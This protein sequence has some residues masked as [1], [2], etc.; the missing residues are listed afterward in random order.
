MKITYV[1]YSGYAIETENFNLLI[2]YYEDSCTPKE[3]GW[4]H[5]YLL[6][7]PKK[8][9]ILSTHSHFDHFNPEILSWKTVK[10]DIVYLFSKD[11]LDNASAQKEDAIYLDKGDTYCDDLLTIKAYGSTDIGV[12]FLLRFDNRSI[13]HAGDLNN[14]HWK[15]EVPASEALEYE[16]NFLNELEL[17]ATNVDY[18]DLAM[19]PVDPR[20]GTEYMRGAEQ[21]IARIRTDIFAPMHFGDE[22]S[23]ASALSSFADSKHCKVLVWKERGEQKVLFNT[24]YE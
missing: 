13:F 20:L 12:S 17:L 16:T 11:I 3:L 21:F 8:L 2:D 14:W 7:Q 24:D 4:V 6:Q 5:T 15:D 9:Y 1:Y 22:Y 10:K 19:F 23:K 18:L